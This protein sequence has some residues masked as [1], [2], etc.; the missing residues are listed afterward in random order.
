MNK[1][2]VFTIV[3]KNYIGLAQI[4]EESLKEKNPD[5][6]F[7][8]MV[9]DDFSDDFDLEKLPS[10]ILTARKE[11]NISSRHWID[12]SFKYDLTEFCTSIK[13]AS[14]SYFMEKTKYQKIVYLDPD[15]YIYSSLNPIYEMLED[16]SIVLTPHI[17]TIQDIFQGDRSESGL[18][19]TGVF[20][21]GFCGIKS[22]PCA[23]KMI[24]WWHERLL[25]KCYIDSHDSYFTDQKWMDFLPCYFTSNELYVS[26]HLGMNIA[27]WNYFERKVSMSEE[28]LKVCNREENSRKVDFPVIFVHYSGYNYT[29][30]KKGNV[31]QNNISN[32]KD[33]EDIKLLTDIYAK[34][35]YEKREI[36]DKYIQ[37]KYS[38]GIFENGDAIKGFHRR[39]Y[40][41]LVNKGLLFDNPFSIVNDSLYQ[42]LKVKGMIKSSTINIDKVTKDNLQGIGR[43]LKMF[44]IVTRLLYK[45]VGFD[46]YVLLIRLMRPFSRFESQIHLITSDF[47]EENI[48]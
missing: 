4:L 17:T 3:A 25:D 29:E 48:K 20:N 33:Y 8:I 31:V 10:N 42:K 47:D 46:K 38:F 45:L 32:I 19:S 22:N 40:R 16:H 30:M 39:I 15:I 44:N 6:D 23:K 26:R 21:L 7:F 12:M 41:S 34:A 9:A 28:G 14:F 2:V 35:I 36:F 5:T 1:N 37:D 13:P 27:P 18:M 24:S 43:K 11:L